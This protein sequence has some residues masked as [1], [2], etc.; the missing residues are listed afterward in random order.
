LEY[1]TGVVFDRLLCTE[2]P[3]SSASEQRLTPC[4]CLSILWMLL[5]RHGE[6]VTTTCSS[7]L[8][9][10]T[11]VWL[12]RT[13][14]LGDSTPNESSSRQALLSILKLA[15]TWGPSIDVERSLWLYFS[16]KLVRLLLM[17]F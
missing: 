10:A 7:T 16:R 13:Q 4:A 5:I 12:V 1:V 14:F 15:H 6:K 11:V 8:K 17:P 9:F 2:C 3:E